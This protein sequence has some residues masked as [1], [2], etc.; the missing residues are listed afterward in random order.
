MSVGLALAGLNVGTPHTDI[1][2]K[3][4][5]TYDDSRNIAKGNTNL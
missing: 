3:N 2:S 5:L 4:Y 1:L